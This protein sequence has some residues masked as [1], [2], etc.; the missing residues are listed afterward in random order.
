[1]SGDWSKAITDAEV[2]LDA[3]SVISK[4]LSTSTPNDTTLSEIARLHMTLQEAQKQI[5]LVLSLAQGWAATMMEGD[6]VDIPNVAVLERGW[7]KKRT[8]WDNDT[9]RR[10]VVNTIRA[11]VE[12]DAVDPETGELT[13]SWES[14]VR[15]LLDAYYL[16]GSNVRIKW[17]QGHGIAAGDYCHEG[18]WQARVTFTKHEERNDEDA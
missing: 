2:L 11:S 5:G 1:M 18:K 9:L 4:E 3:A 8:D 10:D 6:R 7:T 15:P 17:L 13:H 14:V 16:S 12:P